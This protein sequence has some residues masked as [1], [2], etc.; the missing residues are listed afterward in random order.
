VAAPAP[1]IYSIAWPERTSIGNLKK[2]F[3]KTTLTVQ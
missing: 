2:Y 1:Q 3:A